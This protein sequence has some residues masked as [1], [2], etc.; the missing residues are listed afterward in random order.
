MNEKQIEILSIW[1]TGGPTTDRYTVI[2]NEPYFDD[3][4]DVLL[5]L[6]MSANP[7]H[8]QGV[9]LHTSAVP[10]DHLG[11]QIEF[12]DLPEDCQRAVKQDLEGDDE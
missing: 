10:G 7:F 9:C 8:P 5:A 4:S 11:A 2:Y 6:A 1:D 3:N 12:E